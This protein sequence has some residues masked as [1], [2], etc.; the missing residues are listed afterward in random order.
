MNEKVIIGLTSI[1][2]ILSI[3]ALVSNF[4][5]PTSNISANAIGEKE[6]SDNS[7]SASQ[8]VDDTITDDEISDLGISNIADNA[9]FT[10]KIAD[11]T[12][13]TDKLANDVLN[14]EN[15]ENKPLEIVAAGKISRTG[16]I[17]EGY[18]IES[19][20]INETYQSLYV[21]DIKLKGINYTEGFYI[22]VITPVDNVILR[23]LNLILLF[24]I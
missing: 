15:I 23:A 4:V 6:L 8:I 22:T 1:A 12:V 9:I 5:I 14:W 24:M 16:Q 3:V 17:Y 10:N 18:N 2:I 13:T 11:H 20:I 21:Y 7:V 19:V